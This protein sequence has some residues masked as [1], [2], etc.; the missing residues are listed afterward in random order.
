MGRRKGRI[1]VTGGV[2]GITLTCLPWNYIDVS[3]LEPYD[4]LKVKNSLLLS[5]CYVTA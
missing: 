3:T 4:I 1:F 2:N 5:L